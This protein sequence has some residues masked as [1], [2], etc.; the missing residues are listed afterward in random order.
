MLA[1]RPT[2]SAASLED[3]L[4]MMTDAMD[5]GFSPVHHTTSPPVPRTFSVSNDAQLRDIE[6]SDAAGAVRWAE[7]W[8]PSPLYLTPQHV[9]GPASRKNM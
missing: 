7:V 2:A 9:H 6:D 5:S 1:V 3:S 8:R 4:S